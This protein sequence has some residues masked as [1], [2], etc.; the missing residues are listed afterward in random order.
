[1]KDIKIIERIEALFRQAEG[2]NIPEEALTFT[3]K[4][5]ELLTKYALSELDIA[6]VR[7]GRMDDHVL[8]V[9]VVVNEPHA[10]RK[11]SLLSSVAGV[12]DL[13][14]VMGHAGR[15]YGS[16][17]IEAGYG[18]GTAR[19]V[20]SDRESKN[21]RIVYLT[22]FSKDIESTTLLYTSLLIQAKG[23]IKRANIPSWE[24]KA[25][26]VSHFFVGFS[27]VVRQRLQKTRNDDVTKMRAE[28]SLEGVDLLPVIV[29]RAKR[30]EYAYEEVWSGKLGKSRSSYIRS[31][32]SGYSAGREAGSRSDVGQTRIGGVG[33]LGRG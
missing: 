10:K 30:V 32:T 33:A 2:T 28:A 11:A 31:S 8:T 13:K 16:G 27:A 4:A 7:A 18:V 25:T 3:Q 24:N 6:S 9:G 29:E 14:V 5:Q 15:R 1:M 26:W 22:G 12:N 20:S 17:P 21:Y 23:E 19:T